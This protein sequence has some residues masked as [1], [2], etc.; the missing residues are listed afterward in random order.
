MG[1]ARSV[2]SFDECGSPG[3]PVVEFIGDG[4]GRE[5]TTCSM[6]PRSEASPTPSNSP[7][8]GTANNI[9]NI[10]DWDDSLL[11]STY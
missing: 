11:C 10:F 7:G 4:D 2:A 3:R 6:D 1:Q 5:G 8:S 9:C